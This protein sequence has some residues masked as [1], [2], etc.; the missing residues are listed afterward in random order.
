M[1]KK[2]IELLNYSNTIIS[3]SAALLTYGV[4]FQLNGVGSCI[5]SIFVFFS[6]L[7]TYNFQR[8]VRSDELINY[9]SDFL[10]WI[11]NYKKCLFILIVISLSICVFL[12]I[13]YFSVFK[14]IFLVLAVSFV[15]SLLYVLAFKGRAL[16][17]VSYIK[18]YLIAIIWTLVVGIV[19]LILNNQYTLDTIS[20]VFAHFL[21]IIGFCI[22]FD[23]RDL[24]YDSPKLKTLPQIVG[25]RWSVFFS[26][27]SIITYYLMSV[28]VLGW[29]LLHL[30]F[31]LFL[32][33]LVFI[34]SKER[35]SYYYLM[36]DLSIALLGYIYTE[37]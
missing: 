11:R 18:M 12:V 35:S 22:P 16:R 5:Y 26:V 37:I 24:V 28:S 31:V 14:P 27:I 29:S 3:G 8:V 30:L 2:I 15:V 36:I 7:A 1:L 21:L 32:V 34:M 23:V 20:F 17:S 10:N 25:V 13:V 4:S 9:E 19:P 33:V 6:T